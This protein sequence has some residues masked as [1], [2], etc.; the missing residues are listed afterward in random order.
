MEYEVT[1]RWKRST[2][3][4]L[5]WCTPPHSVF[6]SALLTSTDLYLSYSLAELISISASLGDI[7]VEVPED[8]RCKTH[9][10]LD[11]ILSTFDSENV[12]RWRNT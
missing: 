5:R 1:V 11:G 4:L 12:I 2:R 8:G 3:P 9:K 7:G 6:A 10:G